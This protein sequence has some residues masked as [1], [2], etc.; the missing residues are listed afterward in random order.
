V[1]IVGSAVSVPP[2]LIDGRLPTVVVAPRATEQAPNAAVS[3]DTG[4]VGIHESGTALRMDDVAL[5]LVGTIAG[6][7]STLDVVAALAARL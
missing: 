2:E 4:V 5:P 6:P 3:I 7:P 1:L